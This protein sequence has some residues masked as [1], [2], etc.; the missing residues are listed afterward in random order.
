MAD[1]IA[2]LRE[3]LRGAPTV[4]LVPTMGNLH[5]GHLALVAAC[6]ARCDT[7][8]VSIFVNPTQFGPAEDFDSYPRTLAADLA[9]L[10]QAQADVAF[11]PAA[12]EMYPA[13]AASPVLVTAPALAS[14]LCGAKRPGHFDGVATVVAKLF[15]V[16][17]PQ[18]AFFGEKDWQQLTVI[19]AMTE[20][21]NM[22]VRVVGVPTVRAPGGLALSSRNAYLSA[23]ER[24]RAAAIHRC[25]QTTATAIGS[26]E[27]DYAALEANGCRELTAAGLAVEYVA[28]RDAECLRPPRTDTTAVR[29]LA[30]AR[31]GAA[32]LI[33]NVGV[34]L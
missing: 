16:V 10:E 8:V 29:V 18:V 20:A 34:G 3:R 6:R 32:R 4:G 19:R 14:T 5:A 1:T 12:A 13:G 24:E 26:G 22:E 7:V 11:I 28:I 17:R 15:N 21:L 27:R 23:A 31:L 9:Q 33:D 25:L 30:A 2:G